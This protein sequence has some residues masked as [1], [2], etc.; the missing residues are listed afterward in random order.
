MVVFY[1]P[2]YFGLLELHD[3]RVEEL[4]GRGLGTLADFGTD[5]FFCQALLRRAV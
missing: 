4:R 5:I 3:S 1:W 2:S